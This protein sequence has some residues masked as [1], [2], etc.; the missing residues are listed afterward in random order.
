[1]ITFKSFTATL[2]LACSSLSFA[3]VYVPFEF[4]DKKLYQRAD[5][6]DVLPKLSMEISPQEAQGLEKI[7]IANVDMYLFKE[8]ANFMNLVNNPSNTRWTSLDASNKCSAHKIFDVTALPKISSSCPI[9]KHTFSKAQ[10]RKDLFLN[11]QNAYQPELYVDEIPAG[12]VK[13]SRLNDLPGLIQTIAWPLRQVNFSDNL[14][15][16]E[17]LTKMRFLLTKIRMNDLLL[18]VRSNKNL[19]TK[20]LRELK[21][22]KC[23]KAQESE[24]SALTSQLTLQKTEIEEAESYLLKIDQEGRRQ[25]ELDRQKILLAGK[26]RAILPYDNL[27]DADREYITMYVS[28]IMWRFRG[29]GVVERS[30]STQFRRIFYTWMPMNMLGALNGGEYGAQKGGPLFLGLF[31]MWGEYFDMGTNPVEDDRYFD[32]TKMSERGIFQVKILLKT[33]ERD[34]FTTTPVLMAG[35]QMGPLYYFATYSNMVSANH[36]EGLKTSPFLEAI[37]GQ[38]DWGEVLFGA[39]IGIGLSRSLLGGQDSAVHASLESRN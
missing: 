18:K 4:E 12:E 36:Y 23:F 20:M 27:S 16:P 1:M 6:V 17:L 29:G 26:F 5:I 21:D 25:A 37:G 9:T 3:N 14:V 34:G 28:S 8:V 33:L 35:L 39:T 19:Y 15:T 11:C 38:T 22:Q 31:K 30:D 2:L 7:S 10:E 24:L 32:L 13:I